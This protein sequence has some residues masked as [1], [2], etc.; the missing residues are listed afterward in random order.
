M[1]A[2]DPYDLVRFVQAQDRTYARALTEIRSGRKR[3]HWMW[4]AGDDIES[5]A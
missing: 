3:S 5:A 1:N 4:N 2:A